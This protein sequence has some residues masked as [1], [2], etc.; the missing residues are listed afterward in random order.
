MDLW[1]HF[2]FP[3]HYLDRGDLESL[4]RGVRDVAEKRVQ[5]HGAEVAYPIAPDETQEFYYNLGDSVEISVKCEDGHF[6]E[7]DEL[8]D[9]LRGLYLY[10][11]AGN[12]PYQ[13]S[14]AAGIGIV[15][16][17]KGVVGEVEP[18]LEQT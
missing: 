10:L 9:I 17:A 8:R 7:W 1:L 13:T 4:F 16:I 15:G 14:F 3:H 18:E 2:G 12:R 6:F 11:T 5:D